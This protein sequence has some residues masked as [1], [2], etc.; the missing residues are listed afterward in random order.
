M[1]KE[2]FIYLWVSIYLRVSIQATIAL[3][4]Y[5]NG[6]IPNF[7]KDL[8]ESFNKALDVYNKII[9]DNT[10]PTKMQAILIAYL[11]RC[12]EEQIHHAI[13]LIKTKID[14]QSNIT[15]YDVEE[16]YKNFT[17]KNVSNPFLEVIKEIRLLEE[18]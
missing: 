7:Y 12:R 9:Q 11:T 10:E 6:T 8:H 17:E 18:R 1:K 2:E 15:S 16:C 4:S 5:H 13:S 14:K 3:E